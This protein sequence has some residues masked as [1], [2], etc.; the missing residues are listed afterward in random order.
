[1]KARSPGFTEVIFM[2]DNC[3]A[4]RIRAMSLVC[5]LLCMLLLN[6]QASAITPLFGSP[7]TVRIPPPSTEPVAIALADLNQDGKADMVTA[8]YCADFACQTGVINVFISGRKGRFKRPVQYLANAHPLT[9]QVADVN[10]DGRMDILVVNEGCGCVQV[11]LGNGDGTFQPPLNSVLGAGINLAI[12]DFNGDGRMDLALGVT[13]DVFEEK[14]GVVVALGNGDGTF[15]A[16]SSIIETG[17]FPFGIAAADFNGDKNT[18]VAV[19][20]SQHGNVDI[21]LGDGQGGL[22]NSG[23]FHVGPS[24]QLTA[25]DIN[26]DGRMDLAIAS[27]GALRI[28]YGNGDGT[29]QRSIPLTAG[30]G[31]QP[32]DVIAGDFDGDGRLD[33]AVSDQGFGLV[34]YLNQSNG[35]FKKQI[36]STTNNGPGGLASGDLNHDGKLDIVVLP[37]S[38]GD[39][40]NVFLNTGGTS[41]KTP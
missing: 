26:G 1:M 25:A 24:N 10:G 6:Y 22:V 13:F 32:S 15:H 4:Y 19:T 33:L 9:M 18:D 17:L 20:S 36:F 28:A 39:S 38:G 30:P 12:A 41:S 21:L 31:S 7:I 3:S 37:S 11:F 23:S 2:T 34:V 27:E 5:F 8:S 29:F 40:V 16:V 14:G 35:T